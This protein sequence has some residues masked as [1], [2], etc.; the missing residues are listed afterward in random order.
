MH[1]PNLIE[2]CNKKLNF[3]ICELNKIL[4]GKKNKVGG[5]KGK[6][7]EMLIF[8]AEKLSFIGAF[9]ILIYY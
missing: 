1:L 3:S 6:I 4:K 8:E 5:L 7:G 2:M 9:K